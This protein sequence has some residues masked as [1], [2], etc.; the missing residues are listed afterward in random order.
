MTTMLP[1]ILTI[2]HTS[3]VLGLFSKSMFLL[4]LSGGGLGSTPMVAGGQ[5]IGLGTGLATSTGCGVTISI[6]LLIR[7]SIL[8]L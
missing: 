8:G 1:T 2:A 4:S 3:L 5:G 6:L 7:K